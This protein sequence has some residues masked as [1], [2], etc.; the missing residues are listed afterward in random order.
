MVAVYFVYGLAFFTLGVSLLIS[1]RRTSAFRFAAA[2]T[3]L[4]F[5]GLLHGA[6]EWL[7]MFQ[8]IA[9]V[10]DA[11]PFWQEILRIALLAISF[12]FLLVFALALL[13]DEQGRRK[14]ATLGVAAV[15]ILCTV[16]VVATVLVYDAD[17]RTAAALSDVLMRYLIGIPAALLAAW[18]FMAQQRIFRDSDMP[19]FGANLVWC[20]AALVLY[21]SVGQLFVRPTP[22]PFSPVLNSANFLDWFGIPVQLFRAVLAVILT[23]FMLRVLGVFEAEERRR[24]SQSNQARLAAQAAALETEE[25]TSLKLQVVNHELKLAMQKLSL[26]VDITNTL[27]SSSPWPEPLHSALE[28]IVNALAFA[29]AGLILL[30]ASD[31]RGTQIATDF[32]YVQADGSEA[33]FA[34]REAAAALGE[35]CLSDGLLRCAHADGSVLRLTLEA[36]LR[37]QECLHHESPTVQVA[38]PLLSA[39]RTIGG[40]V[41]TNDS[42][43]P[44][45]LSSADLSLMVGIAQELGLSIENALLH[46]QAVDR[47]HMLGELLAQVVSAQEG[48]RK[49]IARELHD[50]TGQS[51]TA[52]GL[53]LRGIQARLEKVDCSDGIPSLLSQLDEVLSYRNSALRELHTIIADL[54]PPQLDE[55][56]LVAALQWYAKSFEQQW[57]IPVHFTASGTARPLPADYSTV[58]FRITQEALRNIAKHAGASQVELALVQTDQVAHL[59]IRDDGRGFDPALSSE[60]GESESGWGLIGMKERV[61]LVGGRLDLV[62]SPGGGTEISIRI[63]LL[64]AGA[65]APAHSHT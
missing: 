42:L 38:L 37:Q 32:G 22:L 64:P 46:R 49:R 23:F 50:A 61:S 11:P 19:Q 15:L 62:T 10:G 31:D 36:A 55:L 52:I 3:S 33:G 35:E 21:G 48:E 5:F 6:H 57:G 34:E 45:L 16:T 41:L 13:G 58:L 7:E 44:S 1:N 9:G 24:L 51:L 2:A 40:L 47:E 60:S 29:K 65:P 63:P 17:A 26:L 20:A 28:Q 8:R 39:N 25:Q 30:P 56:G 43:S 54:R 53:G 27:Q 14:R 18:A 12:T 59:M 4:A